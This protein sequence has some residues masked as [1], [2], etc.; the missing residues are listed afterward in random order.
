MGAKK[1]VKVTTFS[2]SDI[3]CLELNSASL[4]YAGTP[5]GTQPSSL[6]EPNGL[7]REANQPQLRVMFYLLPFAHALSG[8]DTRKGFTLR[9]MRRDPT[10]SFKNITGERTRKQRKNEIFIF[11][12]NMALHVCT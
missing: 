12:K 3:S 8:C 1:S 11:L 4:S 9:K 5:A 6:F 7:L 10:L 2:T